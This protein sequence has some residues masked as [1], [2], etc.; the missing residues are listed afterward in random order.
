MY[1]YQNVKI[2]KLKKSFFG[3][4][5]KSGKL[6]WKPSLVWNFKKIIENQK[7]A[8]KHNL[9]HF[10]CFL[11]QNLKTIKIVTRK[12]E[13]FSDVIKI[14]CTLNLFFCWQNVVLSSVNL[15]LQCKNLLSLF[16]KLGNKMDYIYQIKIFIYLS[17]SFLE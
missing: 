12:T 8:K 7:T 9:R 14:F 13:L 6:K 15:Q 5:C 16:D 11:L 10:T 2:S 17:K 1:W 3:H 4:F